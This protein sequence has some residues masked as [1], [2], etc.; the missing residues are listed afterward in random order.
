DSPCLVD[1]LLKQ[2]RSCNFKI[3]GISLRGLN[4]AGANL[5]PFAQADF[6][7]LQVRVLFLFDGGVIMAAQ[8]HS[9]D[10]KATSFFADGTHHR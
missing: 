6:N 7:P 9:F 2:L 4:T 1:V 3:A 8:Q 5:D 10:S